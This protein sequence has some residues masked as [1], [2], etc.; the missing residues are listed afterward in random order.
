M[1]Q[2]D[3]RGVGLTS[4]WVAASRAVESQLPDALVRD[5]FYGFLG[6]LQSQLRSCISGGVLP[7]F[8]VVRCLAGTGLSLTI[9]WLF[10]YAN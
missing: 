6:D 2:P 7:M 4:L 8:E 1:A 9:E 3:I 10:R 5:P